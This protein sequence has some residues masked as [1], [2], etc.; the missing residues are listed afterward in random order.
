MQ[1]TQQASILVHVHMQGCGVSHLLSQSQILAVQ[2]SYEATA[3]TVH[4]VFGWLA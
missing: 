3:C 1:A 2:V 4:I